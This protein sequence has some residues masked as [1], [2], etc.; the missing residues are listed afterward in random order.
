M[1]GSF[2]RTAAARVLKTA[3]WLKNLMQL[4]LRLKEPLTHSLPFAH[5]MLADASE[6][7]RN[8]HSLK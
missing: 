8:Q 3:E 2:A 4:R 7:L 6:L 5:D 1:A